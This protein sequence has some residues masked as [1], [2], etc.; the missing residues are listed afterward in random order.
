[1]FNESPADATFVGGL[2][3]GP[4]VACRKSRYA[5]EAC[6][7]HAAPWIAGDFPM[8]AVP[9]FCESDTFIRV[10]AVSD[11]PDIVCRDGYYSK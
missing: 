9:V 7:I 5:L 3:D 10:V 4:D 1:M 2:P 8:G 11:R 6:T